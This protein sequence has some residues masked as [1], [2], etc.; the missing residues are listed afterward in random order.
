LDF[1]EISGD[2]QLFLASRSGEGSDAV[3]LHG[4]PDTPHSFE[5]IQAALAQAGWR[6]TVP[7][8]RGYEPRT[9]VPGRRYDPETLGRDVLALL[10]AISAPSALLVGHDWGALASY[11]AA[12]LAPERVD[13]IVA[14]AIPHPSVL[15]RTPRAL[16]AARHFF[17][18]KMPWAARTLRRRDFAYLQKL[19]ERWAPNWSGPEQQESVRRAKEALSTPETLD[20]AIAYYRALPLGGVRLLDRPP[21]VPGL[22][23]GGTADIVD[24]QLFERTAA[25]LP[26]P[27]RA[28]MVS[29]AG[30]WAHREGAEV[31]VPEIVH[32]ASEVRQLPSGRE[33]A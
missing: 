7:W 31:V 2:G 1:G 24:T 5:H 23:V 26:P 14:I 20:G 17:A 32:F 19:Y 16:L 27:S 18:L 13:G 8:L 11:V 6:T 22:I 30:H 28:L 15:R 33:H 21:P 4:F 10:D 3:L 12:T 29:G 25:L 9:I